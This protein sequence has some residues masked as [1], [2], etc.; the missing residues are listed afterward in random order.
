MRARAVLEG[1]GE[2]EWVW[3]WERGVFGFGLVERGGR[4]VRGC[5]SA[6]SEEG[7]GV[8][9]VCLSMSVADV[10]PVPVAVV[11]SV[12]SFSFSF[13]YSV[14]LC[15]VMPFMVGRDTLSRMMKSLICS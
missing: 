15:P 1:E 7:E 6:M 11:G 8:S 13:S 10:V 2:V 14:C 12:S 9:G 3:F 5:E 4:W